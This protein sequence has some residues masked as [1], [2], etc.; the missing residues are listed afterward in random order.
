MARGVT[1][2]ITGLPAAGKT[3]LATAVQARLAA[4]ARPALHERAR[5]ASAEV[6]VATPA[7]E[8]ARRDP[9]GLYRRAA[10]GELTV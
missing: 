1:V 6:W 7:A 5:V 10:A 4:G 2:W 8:C 9:K 3:T